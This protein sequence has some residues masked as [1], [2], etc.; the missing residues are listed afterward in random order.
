VPP[1]VEPKEK[2]IR[3]PL[4]IIVKKQKWNEQNLQTKNWQNLQTTIFFKKMT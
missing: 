4:D 3:G 1:K 2:L